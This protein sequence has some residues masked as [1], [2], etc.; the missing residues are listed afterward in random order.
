[1][2]SSNEKSTP[3]IMIFKGQATLHFKTP[4]PAG[5]IINVLNNIELFS[6][7]H[8]RIQ[9]AVL[10]MDGWYLI[11]EQWFFFPVFYLMRL[12]LRQRPVGPFEDCV[13]EKKLGWFFKVQ[14]RFTLR[15]VH[16]VTKVTEVIHT[17]CFLPIG[18]LCRVWIKK[19][20]LKLLQ[21]YEQEVGKRLV[22]YS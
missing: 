22:S 19:N 12:Q 20:H 2:A 8:P 14:V 17:S 10:R 4:V 7:Y 13:F 15:E 21:R 16:G 18:W 1:M 5:R 6:W 9:D 3:T 11:R